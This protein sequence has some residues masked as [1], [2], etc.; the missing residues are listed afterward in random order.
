MFP[1]AFLSKCQQ[2]LDKPIHRYFDLITGTSTGG[3]IALYLA[4][5]K[6]IDE[7]LQLYRNEGATIFGKRFGGMLRAL[8][9]SIY[10]NDALIAILKHIFKDKTLNDACCRV[11][12]PSVDLVSG[13]A[14]VFKT[15]HHDEYFED[16][17]LPIWIIAAATTAA[18]VYFPPFHSDRKTVY[19]DGG[20]WANNPAFVGLAEAMKLGFSP[21]NIRILSLGTGSTV[22][23]KRCQDNGAGIL[24]YWR[25]GRA[26][27]DIGFLAQSQGVVNSLNYIMGN[28]T[29]RL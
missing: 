7:I 5:G 11:C 20:L 13:K 4:L 2:Q 15:P 29:V 9:G 25:L 3:M 17:K 22:F 21:A 24:S 10:S 6:P 26:L 8:F 18:P 27:V 1:A 12:I 28:T 23:H 19:A 14:K 16:Y